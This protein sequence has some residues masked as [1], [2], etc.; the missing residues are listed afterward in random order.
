MRPNSVTDKSFEFAA[1]AKQ[2]LT[3]FYN[4]ASGERSSG[5]NVHPK[6]DIHAVMKD[7]YIAIHDS[8]KLLLEQ[9]VR[10]LFSSAAHSVLSCRYRNRVI[11]QIFLEGTSM[12]HFNPSDFSSTIPSTAPSRPM[13]APS[14]LAS[15]SRTSSGFVLPAAVSFESFVTDETQSEPS[16]SSSALSH[17][18][19]IIDTTDVSSSVMS[20]AS[21][22][23]APNEMLLRRDIPSPSRFDSLFPL[24]ANMRSMR[25]S[26]LWSLDALRDQGRI[27]FLSDF[28]L[29]FI[30][31]DFKLNSSNLF[32]SRFVYFVAFTLKIFTHFNL[33]VCF[34]PEQH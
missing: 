26:S 6:L 33:H 10:C 16:H 7:V 28:L 32:A 2:K 3:T 30:R 34:L 27:K 21:D 5:A 31:E 29:M 17:G 23:P 18:L 1:T 20:S 9:S 4:K 15:V 22:V 8:M 25:A 24:R 14:E 12:K 13:S 11:L 19:G